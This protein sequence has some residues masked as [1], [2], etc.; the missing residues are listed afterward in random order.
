VSDRYV[1]APGNASPVSQL[2]A[3][4]ARDLADRLARGGLPFAA[5]IECRTA[6]TFDVVVIDIEAEIPQVLEH[7]IRPVERFA[8][9]FDHD[10]AATPDVFALREDF[11]ATPHL[12]P[13][14][15]SVPKRLCLFEEEYADLR[16]RWTAAFFVRRVQDW[17]RLTARGELHA[18]DQPL[19]QALAGAGHG[20]ILPERLSKSTESG[21]AAA[22]VPLRITGVDEY[23]G[24]L[25]ILTEAADDPQ[26]AG[27]GRYFAWSFTSAPH[28]PGAIT[29]TPHTIS[30]LQAFLATQGDD[31]VGLLRRQLLDWPRRPDA[32]ASQLILIVRV[33][34][35][36]DAGSPIEALE[37]WAFLG[38]S[39]LEI[40]VALGIWEPSGPGVALMVPVREDRRG[41]AA[42]LDGL[43]VH[44]RIS[45]DD[46]ARLNGRPGADDRRL[47][48]VG[49]GALGSQV[50]MNSAR[51]GFGRWTIIDR[52]RLLPHNAAR[53]ALGEFGI[54]H[55]KALVVASA[56]NRL[57][58][59]EDVFEPLVA[60]VVLAA[61]SDRE[62]IDERMTHADLVVDFA[63]S[64][65]VARYLAN[66]ALG[67][68]RRISFFLNPVGSDLVMLAEDRDRRTSLDALEMQYYRAILRDERL[69]EHLR[70]PE[71]RI[72]YGTSCRDV[73]L[74]LPQE[75]V[76]LHAATATRQLRLIAD[77]DTSAIRVWRTD[78]SSMDDA[79]VDITVSAVN[80]Q[81]L[82]EWTVLYDEGLL[83]T[84]RGFRTERLPNE[85]G[86]ILLGAFDLERKL[87]YVVDTIPSP[88]DSEERRTL[89]IRGS[90]GLRQQLTAARELTFD[91][92]EYVG[93]WHSHPDGVECSPSGDDLNVLSWL[94]THMDA[95]A[96]PGVMMIACESDRLAVL[97]AEIARLSP[98]NIPKR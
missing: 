50:I 48:A 65:P 66:D 28:G 84:I 3:T 24:K 25:L 85:T 34:K 44:F 94:T 30:E 16:R 38:P 29:T 62:R 70:R 87:I 57:T 54:G 22:V 71:G 4:K 51:A 9:C 59:D 68:A 63:A 60:D 69:R 6:E 33:P 90:E 92:I 73:S 61:G 26:G 39:A 47:V 43:A 64:V 52:D 21:D 53:H 96:V 79:V 11:P 42:A 97:L 74:R 40:G 55:H 7:D 14:V 46:A 95:E 91:Q 98:T 17:L 82:G 78:R 75:L 31:I 41:E 15:D 19:E 72:R 67:S 45:R 23:R 2:A 20:I 10:D 58:D 89:Y 12:H 5:L 76:A 77:T 86:G 18:E 13:P 80:R 32:L 88:A 93:E 35:A 27:A 8:A 49:A 37:T 56:A 36:R 83:E 1:D 81:A